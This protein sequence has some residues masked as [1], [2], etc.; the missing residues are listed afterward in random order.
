ME[1]MKIM[2]FHFCAHRRS[3]RSYIY[4]ILNPQKKNPTQPTEVIFNMELDTPCS[5][6]PSPCIS[7]ATI[8][9][10]S[11]LCLNIGNVTNYFAVR[12]LPFLSPPSPSPSMRTQSKI[13][14]NN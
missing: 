9:S 6:I 5:S 13:D 1:I 8:L 12:S 7:H 3:A 2:L 11:K 4:V 10:L 14:G